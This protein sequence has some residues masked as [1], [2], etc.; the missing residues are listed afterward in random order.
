MS[1]PT[2]RTRPGAAGYR[3]GAVAGVIEAEFTAV[4]LITE[5]QP[6]IVAILTRILDA[7]GVPA[8]VDP[9]IV[10]WLIVVF[11]VWTV[12]HINTVAGAIFG[13]A[14]DWFERQ[15]RAK[16]ILLS[17][18]FGG[19]TS[20]MTSTASSWIVTIAVGLFAWSAFAGVFMHLYDLGG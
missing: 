9:T 13:V 11:S 3:A 20:V 12:V 10:Y 4:M 15:T 7:V 2:M 17:L 14:L 8:V 6:I 1:A 5:Q 19:A 16:V 18:V